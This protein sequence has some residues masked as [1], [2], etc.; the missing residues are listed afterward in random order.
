M[1]GRITAKGALVGIG[2]GGEG[3]E[4]ELLR[5]SGKSVLTCD[6]RLG[7]FPVN[8]SSI[9]FTNSSVVFATAG[10]RLFGVNPSSFDLF[11]LVIVY[12]NV[13]TKGEERLSNLNATLLQIGN[14]TVP[15]SSRWMVCVSDESYEDC[16]LTR[17]SVMKSLIVSVRSEGNYSVKLFSETTSGFLKIDQDVSLFEVAS[18]RSFVTNA[19]FVPDEDTTTSK[20]TADFDLDEL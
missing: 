14:L 20:N 7:K 2:S 10:N 12:G 3:G 17:S 16:Y 15:P 4:I 11:S 5:F 13:T 9:I 18:N 8:A 6:A 1:G 19:S